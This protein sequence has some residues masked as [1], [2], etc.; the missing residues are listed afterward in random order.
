MVDRALI[1]FS[2]CRILEFGKK[3]DPTSREPAKSGKEW[4]EMPVRDNT[5]I[6]SCKY[7]YP[8]ERYT[9]G[10]FARVALSRFGEDTTRANYLEKALGTLNPDFI[11]AFLLHS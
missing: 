1:K 6:S 9:C 2:T 3:K 5:A 11:I 8:R 7:I 4:K 10:N